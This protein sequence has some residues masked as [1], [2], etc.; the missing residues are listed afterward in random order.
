MQG[1]KT[2]T[3]CYFDVNIFFFFLVVQVERLGTGNQGHHAWT[4]AAS[5]AH[6]ID[7]PQPADSHSCWCP[8]ASVGAAGALHQ[9][10]WSLVLVHKAVLALNKR[11]FI[12]K[13][14]IFALRFPDCP[15]TKDPVSTFHWRGS[16]DE[17]SSRA[18]GEGMCCWWQV[19]FLKL[20][21]KEM[22][23]NVSQWIHLIMHRIALLHNVAF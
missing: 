8:N 10:G 20:R 13:I 7:A 1:L 17:W 6:H 16:T 19:C 22:L 15:V 21:L 14:L 5:V 2:K 3:S 12:V 18:G 11:F 9:P 4:P 23:R